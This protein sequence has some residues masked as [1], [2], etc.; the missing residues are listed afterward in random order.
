LWALDFFA[1]GRQ[2]SNYYSS[3]F[4]ISSAID[5]VT[6]TDSTAIVANSSDTLGIAMGL[7]YS[8]VLWK[9][10]LVIYSFHLISKREEGAGVKYGTFIGMI[11][12]L[13]AIDI[14]LTIFALSIY[15][16]YMYFG[17][18][19]ILTLIVALIN[20]SSLNK[21]KEAATNTIIPLS[22]IALIFAC[23]SIFLPTLYK[24]YL[25]N[26]TQMSSVFLVIYGYPVVDMILYALTLYLGNKV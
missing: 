18:N 8:W 14:L 24:V 1:I 3:N 10:P 13:L 17:A 21:T 23:Y 5:S 20:N 9:F 6:Y 15:N 16:E 7:I 11:I 26:L 4:S 22:L 19:F 12:V 2:A 25:L